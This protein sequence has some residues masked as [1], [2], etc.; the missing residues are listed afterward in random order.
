MLIMIF[1]EIFIYKR[2]QKNGMILPISLLLKDWVNSINSHK[3]ISPTLLDGFR[4]QEV[5]DAS[6]ASVL[7]AR[8]ISIPTR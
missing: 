3:P 4:V 2:L 6:H 8:K 5:L 1:L 7:Q